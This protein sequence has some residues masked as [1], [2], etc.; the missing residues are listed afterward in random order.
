MADPGEYRAKSE[1]E[2]WRKRDPIPTFRRWLVED[3]LASE[4]EMDGGER[5]LEVEVEEAIRFAEESPF[6]APEALFQNVYGK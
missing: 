5:E 1:E 3:G 2:E 6:P 4:E